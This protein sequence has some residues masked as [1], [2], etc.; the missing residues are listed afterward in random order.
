MVRKKYDLLMPSNWA[1]KHGLQTPIL[2][3]NQRALEV[4]YESK[5]F[6]DLMDTCRRNDESGD[7]VGR[8]RSGSP[9]AACHGQL[10]YGQ[11]G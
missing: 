11:N 5:Y 7:N 6:P 1:G 8:G 4:P 2:P 9:T 10:Q 3:L